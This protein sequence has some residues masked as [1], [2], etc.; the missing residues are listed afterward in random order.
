MTK[1]KL[2]GEIARAV[3]ALPPEYCRA[4]DAAICRHV[5][6]H[7][8]FRSAKTVF[9]YVGTAREID[10]LPILA[11]ALAAGKTLA[12]PLCTGK[13][14]MEARQIRSLND[15]VPGR[16]GIS[17]PLP[18]CPLVAPEALDLALVPCC[19]GSRSGLRLGYGGGFYDRYLAMTA[20]PA[21][22]LCRER[23]V[24]EDIPTER[25]DRRM[26]LLITESGAFGS[27]GPVYHLD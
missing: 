18:A 2:R 24:R 14:I 26:D 16:Y 10:T 5:A 25:H 1:A 11:A 12:V 9:C 23:L 3:A 4:A 6:E 7:P 13:G 8:L 20:C 15:L 22:M 17:E 19:S 21:V 27:S